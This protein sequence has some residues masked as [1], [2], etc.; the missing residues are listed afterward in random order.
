MSVLAS[1]KVF[2][3]VSVALLVLISFLV[4]RPAVPTLGSSILE[5][6]DASL[7]SYQVAASTSQDVLPTHLVRGVGVDG[8]PRA[9]STHPMHLNGNPNGS[10]WSTNQSLGGVSLATGG[11]NPFEVDLALPADGPSWVIGRSYN[12]RQDDGSQQ[13][14]GYQGQNW[15][16]TSQPEILIHWEV[17]EGTKDAD[18]LLYLIYGADRFIEFQRYNSSSDDFIATNGA[19]GAVEYAANGSG[20]PET[21]TYVDQ[22]GWASTFFGFDADAAGAEGQL[23]KVADPEGN[24]AYAGDASLASD[25][26]TLGYTSG[27]LIVAYDSEDRRYTY[28]YTTLDSVD[29]LTEV[30]AETKTGG[31]SASPTGLATVG[32]VEYDY[33]GDE[34]YGDPGDLKTVTITTPLSE[35]S[36]EHVKT[37]YYRYWEG[38]FNAS[39]NPGHPHSLKL[40]LDYE[41]VRRF[42]WATDNDFDGDY[43]AASHESLEDF[44]ATYLEYDAN[45]RVVEAWFNGSCGCGG[46]GNGT[47]EFEYES[48]GSYSDGSGYDT[49]WATRT[50]AKRPDGS[51]VTQYFD[52]VG[53]SPWQR[54]AG[55]EPDCAAHLQRRGPGGR[56]PDHGQVVR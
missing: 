41:G 17:S 13:S 12:Q 34:T 38:T 25:P 32:N 20:E 53:Q 30:K 44:A 4:A 6:H 39:T 3:P 23:W 31:T 52:E 36:N 22:Q 21:F 26:V 46:A 19:A 45:R 15:F 5:I 24:E 27:R 7:T 11:F 42:D 47:H 28:S 50:V 51:Y 8:S 43:E 10:P 35:S 16:Q 55:H 54:V 9:G 2:L 18:D 40:A 29:R 37:K 49:A 1:R 14:D 56:Y 33:Y 48:N